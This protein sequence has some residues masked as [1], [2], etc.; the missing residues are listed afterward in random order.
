MGSINRFTG[1]ISIN[2]GLVFKKKNVGFFL[3]LLSL[4]NFFYF[5]CF[6]SNFD[7]LLIDLDE[8]IQ[9]SKKKLNFNLFFFLKNPKFNTFEAKIEEYLP[10]FAKQQIVIN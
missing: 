6:V 9:K 4:C 10:P 3:L 7:E 8:R 2:L 5:G 1:F